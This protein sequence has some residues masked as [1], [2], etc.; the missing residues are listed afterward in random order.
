MYIGAVYKK[1]PEEPE[2]KHYG[3]IVSQPPIENLIFE[4][5]GPKGAIYIGAIE[6]LEERRILDGIKNV[7]GSSSG[8]MTALVVGLGY[9]A[10]EIRQITFEQ[11]WSHLADFWPKNEEVSGFWNKLE[12]TKDTLAK[13]L[14]GDEG[15]GTGLCWGN[16]LQNWM[17]TIVQK[18]VDKAL[19]T[20]DDQNSERYNRALTM[21]DKKDITF[22]DLAEL[23]IL[24]PE[25]NIR[26]ISVTGANITDQRLEIFNVHNTPDM[27]VDLA[28]RISASFPIFFKSIIYK[29]K[30]YIDGGALNNYPMCIYDMAPYIK[31][32]EKKRFQGL[33]GQN[34]CTLGFR[35][36]SSEEIK[37]ILWQS[38][39][40]DESGTVQKF[41]KAIAESSKRMAAKAI[42]SVDYIASKKILNEGIYGMYAQRTVQLPD[43]NYSSLSTNLDDKD[44]KTLTEAGAKGTEE[45]LSLYYD[46]AG[47]E[48]EFNELSELEEYLDD[49]PLAEVASKLQE[50]DSSVEG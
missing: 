34:L 39:R 47:I 11:D 48:L 46:D 23:G 32:S 30:E 50:L 29:D 37:E 9:S 13:R 17:A 3:V 41:L 20:E 7:G 35:V 10:A 31:E 45:W 36:D 6:V 14:F 24:F 19:E 18:R 22:A 15:K 16:N 12:K 26:D 44:I 5:S 42:M 8:A 38:G 49:Q 21:R 27:P 4:G 40:E 43:S 28:V 33:Y 1:N 25:L 2:D